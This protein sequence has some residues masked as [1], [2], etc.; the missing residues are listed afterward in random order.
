MT[1]MPV[2]LLP[3]CAAQTGAGAR[4]AME[5]TRYWREPLGPRLLPLDDTDTL[6]AIS[7]AGHA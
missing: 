3:K 1:P 4:R 5:L 7:G 6:D 2:R